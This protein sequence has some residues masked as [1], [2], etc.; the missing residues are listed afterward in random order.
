MRTKFNQ[1]EWAKVIGLVAAGSRLG[2][3]GSS[4]LY[5]TILRAGIAKGGL[6]EVLG[7]SANKG[8]WRIIFKVSAII[9]VRTKRFRVR[10][11]MC[12]GREGGARKGREGRREVEREGGREKQGGAGKGREGGRN[13][14]VQVRGRREVEREGERE[15]ETRRCR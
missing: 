14:E 2:S 9:Q 15:G 10:T 13:K 3:L 6:M 5:G 8:E 7:L 12:R 4:L 1:A 11:R